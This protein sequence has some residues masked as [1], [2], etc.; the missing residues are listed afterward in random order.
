MAYGRNGNQK[1]MNY[2]FL[3]KKYKTLF[4]QTKTFSDFVHRFGD[5]EWRNE[6]HFKPQ[7][8]FTSIDGKNKLDFIGRFENLYSDWLNLTEEIGLTFLGELGHGMKSKVKVENYRKY[9]DNAS[10]DIIGN[11]YK[12]DIDNFNYEF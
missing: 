11:I 12:D 6:A 4:F 8:H 2:S 10:R 9:Y 7:I 5:S 1:L 3:E